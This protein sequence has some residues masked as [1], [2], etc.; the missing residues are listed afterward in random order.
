[1]HRNAV[2]AAVHKPALTPRRMWTGMPACQLDM[3]HSQTSPF[4]MS[5][6][7]STAGEKKSPM[8]SM[9]MRAHMQAARQL[10]PTALR[11]RWSGW[12]GTRAS[13]WLLAWAMLRARAATTLQRPPPRSSP[14]PVPSPAASVRAQQHD[15]H[16]ACH[17]AGCQRNGGGSYAVKAQCRREG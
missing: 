15:H 16:P 4:C 2:R 13:P 14:S 7:T 8:M 3:L 1:M 9:R 10:R 6:S 11:E 12:W 17:G 5:A